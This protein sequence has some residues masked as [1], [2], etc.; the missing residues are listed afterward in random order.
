VTLLGDVLQAGG[1]LDLWRQMRGFTV[2]ISIGGV[3]CAR[4]CRAALLKDLVAEGRTQQQALEITGF[5]ASDQ[6][7]LYRRDWVALE[8]P[9]GQM[10]RE[11]HAPPATFRRHMRSA[12]WDDLQLAHYCGYLIWNYVAVPFILADSDV[13]TEELE[14]SDASG[15]SWRRLKVRFPPRVVT[16]SPEQTFYFDREG[17]LRR[18]HYPAVDDDQTQIAQVFWEHQR[19][20]GILVPT[21]CRISKIGVSGQLVAEPP[22]LDI[23]IFDA[24]FE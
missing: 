24:V 16:H 21:L 10:L 2:H 8:G 23:E 12:T 19:F 5:N 14:S 22:L 4:K 18:V 9:D 15:E 6:R 3:L 13:I 11:R 17:L 20:S 1:G 7:A